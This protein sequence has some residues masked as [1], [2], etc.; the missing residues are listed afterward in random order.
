MLRSGGGALL[1]SPLVCR[2][3]GESQAGWAPHSLPEGQGPQFNAVQF[4][5]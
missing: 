3:Q 2:A 5:E 4:D 1:D